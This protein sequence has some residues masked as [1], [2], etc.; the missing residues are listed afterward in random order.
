MKP[1]VMALVWSL[2]AASTL[3]AQTPAN[4]KAGEPSKAAAA[5]APVVKCK[6]PDAKPCT[7][8]QVQALSDAVYS[9]KNHHDALVP[10]KELTLAASDGSLK[11]AQGDGTP[12]TTPQLD[13]I[14]MIAADQQLYINYNS[15]KSNTGNIKE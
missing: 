9:G 1:I 3:L 12:C 5:A 6:G 11:C 15:S 14:K 4:Q 7:A 2:A 8:K 10:V 13:A